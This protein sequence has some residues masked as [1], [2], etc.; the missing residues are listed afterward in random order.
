MGATVR[1]KTTRGATGRRV[2]LLVGA[3]LLV[4]LIA[5][6]FAPQPPLVDLAVVTRGPLRVAIE[7]EGK[8]RVR[9]RYVV[10][11][12]VPG[13]KHRLELDVGDPVAKGQVV[14]AIEPLRSA[15]LDPRSRAEAQA[16]VAAAQAA[17]QQAEQ[18]T[19]A[20][21]ADASLAQTDLARVRNLHERGATTKARLDEAEARGRGTEAARRSAGFAVEV[22]RHQLEAARA[23]LAS[24][25]PDGTEQE[26]IEV[27]SP[28][29]GCVLKV[30]SE[31]EGVVSA[32]APLLEVGDPAALEV[33]VEVLSSDAVKLAVGTRALLERWGGDAPLEGRVRRVEP[34][35]FTKV[36]ALGVEEQRVLTIVELASPPEAWQRLG[37]GYRVEAVFVLWEEQDVLQVPQSVLFS[38]PAGV[39][40][41]FVVGADDKVA[42]RAL[43][44]GERN[45]LQAQVLEGLVEG[46]RVVTHPP[47]A[48]VDG[49]AVRARGGP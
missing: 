11:S 28:V 41:A 27:R 34:V 12:P 47:D 20:A 4:G 25:E 17:L 49:G 30:W 37:D 9:D 29:A 16:R 44:V 22:A 10:S 24:A 15:A 18:S 38:G 39:W 6:G 32:G 35:G 40:Q 31:S 48:L 21:E 5:K 26:R 23:T 45:G 14:A 19:Q 36:S 13:F 46:D 3:A 8:T 43:K 7:E 42:L 1:P 33:E 2:L